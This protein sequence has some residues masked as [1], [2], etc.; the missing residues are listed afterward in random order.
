MPFEF[1][2]AALLLA[3]FPYT[4]RCREEIDEQSAYLSNYEYLVGFGCRI[5]QSA[6]TFAYTFVLLMTL[7]RSLR[8]PAIFE[9]TK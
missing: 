3:F 6:Y 9:T 1:F 8:E 4:F 2:S 7:I 5:L